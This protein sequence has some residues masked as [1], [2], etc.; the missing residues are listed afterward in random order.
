[1]PE[2]SMKNVIKNVMK[3]NYPQLGENW[4]DSYNWRESRVPMESIEG[5]RRPGGRNMV[6]VRKIARDIKDGKN[7]PPI[8]VVEEGGK[9][10]VVDGFHRWLGHAHAECKTINC[11]IGE[12]AWLDLYKPGGD[13]YEQERKKTAWLDLSF[14]LLK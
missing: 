10:Y 9:R 12:P 13:G 6:K 11:Y 14:F 5:K 8:I 1:M 3:D 2:E 4:A 7:M